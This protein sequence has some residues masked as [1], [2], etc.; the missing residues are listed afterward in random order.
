[1]RTPQGL[2]FGPDGNLYVVEEN[3]NRVSQWSVPPAPVSAASYVA[4]VGGPGHAGM[5]PSGAEVVPSGA[6]NAGDIVVADTGNDRVAEYTPGGNLVWQTNPSQVANEGSLAAC[7]ANPG[8]PQFEQPRDVGVDA[9]GNVYVADNGNG[10]IVVLNGANG[11]C[12]IPPIKL[13]GGAAIGVTVSATASG[14][15][16]YVANAPKNDVMVFNTAGTLEQTLTSS[17]A[18]VINRARDAAAN[19]SGNV[20]VANYESNNILEF[21]TTGNCI[22]TFGAKRK[23]QRPVQEPVRRRDRHRPVHQQRRPRRGDL[24]SRLE[25]RAHP[26]V[27]PRR[28]L[29]GEHRLVGLEHP[30]RHVH[31]TASSRRR[32]EW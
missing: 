27:H 30:D 29:G 7:G 21:G 28:H 9:S 19:S 1:M 20:Y 11:K 6:P 2:A 4:T 16:V 32:R 13:H 18:C 26:G 12:L 14:D 24:R 17:G 25:Q 23:R 22:T 10:R 8:Y 3:N 5:Y 15:L 31:A